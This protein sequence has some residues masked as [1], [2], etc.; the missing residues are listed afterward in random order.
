MEPIAAELLM[1]FAGSTAGAAGQQAWASLRAL[2]MRHPAEGEGGAGGAGEGEEQPAASR[3]VEELEARPDSAE[4]AR[5]LAAALRRRADR[6]PAFAG[7]FTAWRR[8]AEEA[9]TGSGDVHNRISGGRQEGVIMGRDFYGP[10]DL[11]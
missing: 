2:V 6:D 4:H 3:E 11:G 9:A 8:R 7:E 1:A 10:I 5:R